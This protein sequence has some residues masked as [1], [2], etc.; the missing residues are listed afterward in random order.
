MVSNLRQCDTCRCRMAA[1]FFRGSSTCKLCLLQDRLLASERSHEETKRKYDDLARKFTSLHDFVSANVACSSEITVPAAEAPATSPSSTGHGSRDSTV[2]LAATPAPPTTRDM[3]RPDAATEEP[4]T[5]VRNGAR[6]ITNRSFLPISTYNRFAVLLEEE[7]EDHETRLIGDSI[8]K[9]Q[10]EEFCGRARST[11]KRLC[12]PGGR[13][14]DFTAACDQATINADD[15]TLFIIHAGTNDVESTRSE[16]LMDKYKNM[17]QAFKGKTNNL[18]IS[19]ILPRVG[20][21]V[22]FYNRAFSANNR[23]KTLCAK[24]GVDFINMWDDFYG[25]PSLFLGDGLHLNNVGSARY[26]RLLNNRVLAFRQ[27]NEDSPPT[28]PS[29]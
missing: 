28:E 13:L 10:L 12:M 1:Y 18:I 21:P 16:E 15:N 9:G 25:K 22:V 4:F 5:Q 19:G 24:E 2:P 23:L 6:P 3:P 20:A 26:G 17:I 14:D 27:K 8:V 11:R 7:E 29:P